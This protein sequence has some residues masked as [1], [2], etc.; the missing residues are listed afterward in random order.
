MLRK[1]VFALS[2]AGAVGL[3][4]GCKDDQTTSTSGPD[5]KNMYKSQNQYKQGGGAGTNAATTTTP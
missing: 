3:A 2:L 5:P 4:A 1:L